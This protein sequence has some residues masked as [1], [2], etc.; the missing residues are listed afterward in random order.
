MDGILIVDKP[1]GITSH[2]VVDF[3]RSKLRIR[4]VGHAGTLDPLATG[5]L[6]ILIGK[7]TKLSNTLSNLDKEYEVRM[8]LGKRTD[9]GDADGKIIFENGDLTRITIDLVREV[10][11]KFLGE[12]SQI[13]PMT[14]AIRYKGKKLYELARKGINVERT[15][16]PIKIKELELLNFNLP[17]IMVRVKCSKGTYV[18]VLCDD[19]GLALGCGAYVSGIKR[20]RSGYFSINEAFSIDKL[21]NMTKQEIAQLLKNKNENYYKFAA[22]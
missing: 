11:P 16:R 4:K 21:K 20:L 19:I 10:L 18:R 1:Q 14:S 7:A 6:V 2:D 15:P 3:I 12:L 22:T 8:T 5:V 13:P 17:E 9:T